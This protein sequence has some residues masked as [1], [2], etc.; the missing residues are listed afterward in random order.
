M[1]VHHNSANIMIIGSKQS[2]GFSIAG[3]Q[4]GRPSYR[5]QTILLPAFLLGGG[6]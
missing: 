5:L 1:I 2:A 3:E 4:P 6:S